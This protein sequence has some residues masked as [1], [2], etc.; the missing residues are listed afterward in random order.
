MSYI[1]S[2]EDKKQN[3]TMFLKAKPNPESSSIQWAQQLKDAFQFTTLE[4]AINTMEE[5]LTRYDNVF[6]LNIPMSR[7]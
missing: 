2:Y 6:V 7:E 5:S 1:I 4:T 3:S